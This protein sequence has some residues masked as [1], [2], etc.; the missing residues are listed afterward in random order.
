MFLFTIIYLSAIT[1]YLS[2][3]NISLDTFFICIGLLSV[4][5]ALGA[6]VEILKKIK[7]RNTN[8]TN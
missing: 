1:I 8:Q 4:F 7:E 6:I 5:M 2:Q 3:G